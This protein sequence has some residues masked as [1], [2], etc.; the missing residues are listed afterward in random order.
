MIGD[1]GWTGTVVLSFRTVNDYLYAKLVVLL[2]NVSE[3]KNGE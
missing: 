1:R 3:V 2:S